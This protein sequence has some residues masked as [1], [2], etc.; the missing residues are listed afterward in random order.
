MICYPNAKINLGLKIISKRDDGLHNIE[1]FFLPIPLYDILEVKK[2]LSNIEDIQI[3][4]SGCKSSQINND[5]VL[6]AFNIL[7]NDYS[8]DPIRVHLHKNIPLE[9][10]LGGGSS[11]AATLI[12]SLNLQMK[13]KIKKE[14]MLK[15]ANQVGFDVPINLVKKNTLLIG[16]KNKIL[17]INKKFRLIVLIVYPNIICSTKKIFKAIKSPIELGNSLNLLS[18]KLRYFKCLKSPIKSGTVVICVFVR[19]KCTIFLLFSCES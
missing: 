6:R 2:Q 7:Q 15:I 11:N 13:L 10:G 1:S 8:L 5:L 12:N 4:Y 9:S 17:R 18:F 16:K 3:T 14:E 19:S